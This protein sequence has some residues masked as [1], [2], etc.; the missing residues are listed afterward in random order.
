MDSAAN[1]LLKRMKMTYTLGEI[2]AKRVFRLGETSNNELTVLIGKPAQFPDSSDF[3]VPYQISGTGRDSV[4]RVG[5][6]DAIQCLQLVMKGISAEL[7]RIN[8][9]NNGLLRWE[10]DESGSLGFEPSS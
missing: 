4:R 5:G 10:G 2:I 6:I 3:Y 8:R 9:E 1:N 7:D